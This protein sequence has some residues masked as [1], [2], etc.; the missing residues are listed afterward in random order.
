MKDGKA[1]EV[2]NNVVAMYELSKGTGDA[3]VMDEIVARYYIAHMT[4]LE[5]AAA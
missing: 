2:D 3:V 1:N 4:E 5:D